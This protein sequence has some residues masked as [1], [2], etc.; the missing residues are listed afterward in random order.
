MAF[1]MGV[2][3]NA[4]FPEH[5]GSGTLASGGALLPVAGIPGTDVIGLRQGW[6]TTFR[7]RAGHHVWFHLPVPTPLMVTNDNNPQPRFVYLHI[8]TDTDVLVSAVNVWDSQRRRLVALGNPE[9]RAGSY[10]FTIPDVPSSK[11][12]SGIS[13]SIEI[14]FAREGNVVFLG[15]NVD[16]LSS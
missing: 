9:Y 12:S 2:H 6:G 8:E 10:R 4:V 15:A 16:S 14:N 7:G 5:T 11:T 3:G 13:I 1:S